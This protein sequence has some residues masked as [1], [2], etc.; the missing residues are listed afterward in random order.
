MVGHPAPIH[1]GSRSP[2]GAIPLALQ[3]LPWTI[4][5]EQPGG[6]PQ[7]GGFSFMTASDQT[8]AVVHFDGASVVLREN[9]ELVVSEVLGGHSG[10][11]NPHRQ[12]G[13]WS[14]PRTVIERRGL[15]ATH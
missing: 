4:L 10:W 15:A 14:I 2:I 1:P 11:S 5:P 7:P 6:I 8:V 12:P 13:V 3:S 9:T